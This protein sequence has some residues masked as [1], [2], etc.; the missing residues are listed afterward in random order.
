MH[1]ARCIRILIIYLIILFLQQA[2]YGQKSKSI[3][4]HG[5]RVSIIPPPGYQ[6]V[7]NTS[8]LYY[9]SMGVSITLIE[10]SEPYNQAIAN[11]KDIQ[12]LIAQEFTQ[13][14]NPQE[15]IIDGITGV[16]FNLY[17]NYGLLSQRGV[18]FQIFVIG[19]SLGTLSVIANYPDTLATKY[20]EQIAASVSTIKWDRSKS[21]NP[22]ELLNFSIQMRG[23]FTYYMSG[24]DY[25]AY[26]FNG[27]LVDSSNVGALFTI[28]T[29]QAPQEQIPD[30]GYEKILESLLLNIH[31]TVKVTNV[32]EYN[33]LTLDG[34]R[35]L[36]AVS[37]G[38]WL[39]NEKKI[40]IYFALLVHPIKLIGFIGISDTTDFDNYSDTFRQITNSFTRKK[41]L[42]EENQVC[43]D[44]LNMKKYV[45]A[46][47]CFDT[48]LRRN[49]NSLPALLGKADAL[50]LQNKNKD[51]VVQYSLVIEKDNTNEQAYLGRAKSY[52]SIEKYTEAASDYDKVLAFN[53]TNLS[54][55]LEQARIY[56]LLGIHFKA[57]MCYDR[58]IVLAPDSAL[59]YFLRG[60]LPVGETEESISFLNKA[61][62]KNK[63]YDEAYYKRAVLY[64]YQDKFT[65][66]LPDLSKAI[67]INPN[68]KDY[69]YQRG[70]VYQF[71]EKEK[72]ALNDFKQSLKIQPK[73]KMSLIGHGETE[74][75]LGL[76][77]EAIRDFQQAIDL[78]TTDEYPHFYKGINCFLKSDY[79]QAGDEFR[80]TIKRKDFA[81]AR[82]WL[83][84]SE[85]KA[86]GTMQAT[87]NLK[88]YLDLIKVDGY[89]EW[90]PMV[91][92]MLGVYTEEQLFKNLGNKSNVIW[93]SE[94]KS[95]KNELI[96]DAN[97]A[98]G[99]KYYVKGLKIGA[100]KYWKKCVDSKEK[101]IVSYHIAKICL[102]KL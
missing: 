23:E 8:M 18:I 69:Y 72:D 87:K 56:K 44:L 101:I 12:N 32:L 64:I 66:A 88:N 70:Y 94:R 71:L 5:T 24:A 53:S 75:Y 4:I 76:F 43:K 89:D 15:F 54:V 96:C 37:Y 13:L 14:N 59:L 2:L 86:Y 82:C 78:D 74:T 31:P 68:K 73:D 93:S 1:L 11:Y 34:V 65:K 47:M 61:I 19:D 35:G 62:E 36:E 57:A 99:M 29:F 102:S 28:K 17:K 45:Q 16:R 60:D 97:F 26:T 51:A 40:L 30:E 48:T 92:F 25:M 80:K 58:A 46:E 85:F 98:V 52:T 63:Y 41:Y 33:K 91:K 9:D 3:L 10:T 81:E 27:R 100:K 20:V 55:Y 42:S 79:K 7:G 21:L 95:T 49:P 83:Y 38:Y 77:E 67:Q 84:L 90:I 6:L 39:Y 22:L 50:R